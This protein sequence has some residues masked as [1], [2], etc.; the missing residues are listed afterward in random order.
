MSLKGYGKV[1]IDL[2]Y[3]LTKR[4]FKLGTPEK[5]FSDLGLL[6]YRNYW[7]FKILETLLIFKKKFYNNNNEN[8]F[9]KISIDDLSNYTGMIYNDVIIGLEQLNCLI[10]LNG[11][12]M[13]KINWN[14]L[15]KLFNDYN[16]KQ[17]KRYGESNVITINDD[18]LIWKPILLGPSGGI[19]TI[20]KMILTNDSE[21][22][23]NINN[24]N[25]NNNSSGTIINTSSKISP[26]LNFLNDDVEDDNIIEDQIINK[27]IS[28]NSN[29]NNNDNNTLNN[30]Y[31]IVFPGM[32]NKE[33]L[34]E[35]SKILINLEKKNSIKQQ[36]FDQIESNSEIIEID[37]EDEED[38]DDE[39]ENLEEDDHSSQQDEDYESF[40]DDYEDED[41]EDPEEYYSE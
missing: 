15:T 33:K 14:H 22:T 27:L 36:K 4:E 35:L 10:K 9:P 28:D 3:L 38:E 13:I 40:E 25:N 21:N 30:N 8:S 29:T 37:D 1:L 5:P 18:N 2:S 20:S 39:E 17:I 12:Y 31:E 26:I 41:E 16:E 19:N 23:N 7:K 11:K 32:N 34:L 6:T 24:N